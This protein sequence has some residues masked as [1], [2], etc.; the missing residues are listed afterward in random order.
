VL[1]SARVPFGGRRSAGYGSL[2]INICTKKQMDPLPAAE[3]ASG[4]FY[5]RGDCC[6]RSR[7]QNIRFFRMVD[8]P[9]S[10]HE[11]HSGG[12]KTELHRPAG[13]VPVGFF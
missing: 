5:T 2:F 10:V 3:F 8:C 7:E 4:L 11:A 6:K 9:V 13:S 12:E 1:Q